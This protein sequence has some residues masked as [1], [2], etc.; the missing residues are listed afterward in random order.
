MKVLGLF[1]GIGGFELGLQRAGYEIAATC[2]IDPYCRQVLAK[3]WP[4]VPCYEDVRKLT[5]AVVRSIG[6]RVLCGGFP[7]QDVSIAGD[8]AGLDGERSGLWFQ[9]RRVIRAG[10]FEIVIVE[11]TTGL[12]DLGM[13]RVLAD[14]AALGYDAIWHGIP[15]SAIGAAHQRDRIW[16]IAYR[17]SERR[18]KRTNRD[19]E[20]AR[21]VLQNINGQLALS[22]AGCR[23]QQSYADPLACFGARIPDGGAARAA[24]VRAAL[25]RKP[26]GLSAELDAIGALG[27]AVVPPLTE[28]IGRAILA[29]N[30]SAQAVASPS[31]TEQEK[32]K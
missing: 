7:C 22:L 14:L 20:H 15:A 18:G 1:S 5:A 13:G 10:R 2:E 29:G 24:Y 27:N 19:R 26:D 4:G 25:R 23:E 12:L 31:V 32:Q 30:F 8:R 17:R 28:M 3:H 16:I 21:Q 9:M 11:N 6:A